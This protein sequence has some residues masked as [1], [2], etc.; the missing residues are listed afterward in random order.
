MLVT[1]RGERVELKGTG[2]MFGKDEEKIDH[3]IHD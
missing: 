1:L 2:E 3:V